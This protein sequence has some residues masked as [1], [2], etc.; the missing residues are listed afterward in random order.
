MEIY[1]LNEFI[2]ESFVIWSTPLGT[3]LSVCTVTIKIYETF[4]AIEK[5]TAVHRYAQKDSFRNVRAYVQRLDLV[6]IGNIGKC[7][8]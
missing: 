4:F 6:I 5:E 3:G 8:F 2:N 7:F 1:L